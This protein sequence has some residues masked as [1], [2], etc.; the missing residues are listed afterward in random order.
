MQPPPLTNA[1]SQSEIKCEVCHRKFITENE[2][3][4]L[5]EKGHPC[6]PSVLQRHLLQLYCHKW[7]FTNFMLHSPLQT[8]MTDVIFVPCVAGTLDLHS[9]VFILMLAESP[10]LLQ[11]LK[12]FCLL[13]FCL[14]KVEGPGFILKQSKN[15]LKI[16]PIQ[17]WFSYTWKFFS[18]ILYCLYQI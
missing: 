18:D 7:A 9:N 5:V 14:I 10:Y 12:F 1:Y 2:A 15:T 4:Y 8:I 13:G 17:L 16:F 3:S 11:Y 6:F